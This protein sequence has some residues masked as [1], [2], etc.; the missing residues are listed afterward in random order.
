M[1]MVVLVICREEN[2]VTEVTCNHLRPRACRK[3]SFADV[4]VGDKVMLNY[5][6]DEPTK[7][8]YWY[9]AE[10]TSKKSSRTQKEIIATV[11]IG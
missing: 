7:R 10:I 4:A 11:Y 3:V 5:N 9:D 8:G 6:Y 1:M 2:E